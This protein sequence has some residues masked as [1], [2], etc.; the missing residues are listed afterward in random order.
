MTQTSAFVTQPGGNK[1]AYGLSGPQNGPI[2]LLSNSLMCN[3]S[4][5]D[6]FAAELVSKGFRVLKY[7][8]TGHGRSS[9]PKDPS[10]TTFLTL[11]NDVKF[12]LEQL[13]IDKLHAWVGVSMGAATGIYFVT[14]N[15]GVVQ[16]LVIVDTI[17]SS[18]SNAGI[19]DL[20]GPR[21]EI[22]RTES[23]AI[24]KL[25][26]GTLERWF[27]DEW[28]EANPAETERMR[29]LMHT[30]TKDGFI[31]CCNALSDA[32]FDLR[33]LFKAV[34][35]SVESVLLVVGELDANLPTTMENMRQEIQAG[36]GDK[37]QVR[38]VIIKGAG[39]VP[40]IDGRENFDREILPF[41]SDTSA[42]KI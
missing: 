4:S 42:S 31:A 1:L 21:A 7:D 39:H 29:K 12:L 38:L 2:I 30:T 25:T 10:M 24:I 28:R 19:P 18:P 11:S 14:Q 35:N 27:T 40:F 33:P 22:A 3:Y 6:H 32:S 16:K 20:F 26:A 17:S 41:F 13:K 23:E 36:F 8:Q 5:W 9:P 15:P 37:P 34:G